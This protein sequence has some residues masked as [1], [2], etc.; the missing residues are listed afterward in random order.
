MFKFGMHCIKKNLQRGEALLAV[1]HRPIRNA[2][3]LRVL[4]ADDDGA[5]EMLL[6]PVLEARIGNSLDVTPE[7]LPL[8]FGVPYVWPLVRRHDV[9][10]HAREERAYRLT[11]CIHRSLRNAV[12]EEEKAADA[13]L[14]E[15][16]SRGRLE[17]SL[18]MSLPHAA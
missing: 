11:L 8:P 18:G 12:A 2:A 1:N 3:G 14:A 13:L 7:R 17:R 16:E 5:Q 6:L 10:M 4:K 9:A 15:E